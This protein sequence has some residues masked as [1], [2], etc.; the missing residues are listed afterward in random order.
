MMNRGH[1]VYNNDQNIYMYKRNRP[2]DPK[3]FRENPVNSDFSHQQILVNP[4]RGIHGFISG[5]NNQG[6]K[7]VPKGIEYSFA[8]FDEYM[9]KNFSNVECSLVL[10]SVMNNPTHMPMFLFPPEL[11]KTEIKNYLQVFY[12]MGN[13]REVFVRNYSGMR[14]KNELG[15]IKKAP[16]LKAAWVLLDEPVEISQK[17]ESKSA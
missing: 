16:A 6:N 10:D 8:N 15:L 1:Y 9:E 2:P 11:S 7:I 4:I 17:A 14:Y 12:H 5:R 3:P 13:I